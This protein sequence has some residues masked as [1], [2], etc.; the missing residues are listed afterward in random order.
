VTVEEE[1][2]TDAPPPGRTRRAAKWLT[3]AN[4]AFNVFGLATGPLLARA[5]GADGRGTLAA[6]L[7]P[8]Q[9][10]PHIVGIG[11]PSFALRDAARGGSPRRLAA[12]LGATA[13]AVGVLALPLVPLVATLLAA[14]RDLVHT[15]LLV[16]LAA[17]P[18]LVLLNVLSA[19]A[20]GT[21]QLPVMVAVRVLAPALSLVA[22]I[23]L[24]ALDSLTVGSAAIANLGGQL[25]VFIP[26]ATV[27]RAPGRFEVVPALARRAAGFG[28]RAWPGTLG[29]LAAARLDQLFMIPIVSAE[30]LGYYVVAY[31]VST[32][33]AVIGTAFQAVISPRVA[34]E[35]TRAV[36]RGSR[37]LLPLL[38]ATAGA[39]A[40]LSPV[41]L[42]FLFGADFRAAVPLSLILLGAAVPGQL[43]VYLG[44]MLSAAG[45]PTLYTNGHLIAFGITLPGLILTLPTFGVY[46]AA[47]VSCVAYLGQLGYS[48]RRATLIF[49]GTTAT[50]LV[51][52]RADLDALRGLR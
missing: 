40:V 51:P 47:V 33:P 50:Y 19:I 28:L 41:L 34:R 5:L 2:G 10:A 30:D 21:E 32:G 25:A 23:V 13:L 9:I 46:G 31:T 22:L 7:V 8:I 44:Q 4:I 1:Q 37:L 42:P 14:D 38:L 26:A 24:W 43:S 16:G 49:G 36:S 35:D 45:Y 3:A 6:I 15:Y 11:L 18:V 48:L 29:A 39:L 20:V 27:L 17:A 52:R 12:T